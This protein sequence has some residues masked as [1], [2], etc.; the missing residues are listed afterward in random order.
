M[1]TLDVVCAVILE[2][3]KILIGRRPPKVHLENLW[4]FPGG[5]MDRGETKEAALH[6]EIQEER[7]ISI[8]IVR[9]LETIRHAYAD[10]QDVTLMLHFFLCRRKSGQPH[11]HSASEIR[12]ATPQEMLGLPFPEADRSLLQKLSAIVENTSTD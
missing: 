6:R 1:K 11:P 9:F 3:G 8:E 12:W 5:K 2:N 4:E 10:R 7:G